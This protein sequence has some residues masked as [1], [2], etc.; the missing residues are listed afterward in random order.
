MELETMG[1]I[2]L[3]PAIIAIV[4][5]FA[6]KNTIVALLTA[7]L[8]GT[9]VSG[10]GLL[11]LPTLIKEACGTTSFSWVMLLNLYI[12]IIVAFFHK[13][14]AIQAFSDWVHGKN[15]SRRGTQLVAWV[16]GI[17]VYFSDSF[18]PLFVGTVMRDISDRALISKEKLSYIA[19]S[20]AAP[21]I[22]RAS[23]RERV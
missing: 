22:G 18:S 15:L 12:A 3:L 8:V 10:Q 9:L 13:T 17:F 4:L 1:W 6:T 11:G 16:L 2:S 14:G 21:E 7:C 20:T 23:C 19:D 5:S